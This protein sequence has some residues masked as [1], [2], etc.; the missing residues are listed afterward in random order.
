[1]EATNQQ[2]KLIQQFSS[3]LQ[4]G[5][6]KIFKLPMAFLAGIKIVKVDLEQV[7]TSL[8]YKYVN[9]NPFQSVYFAV[10]NMGAE[11]ASG[12][13]VMLQ[14]A[15]YKNKVS[16]LVV[17]SKSEYYKKATGKVFFTC[18]LT[19]ELQQTIQNTIQNNQASTCVLEVICTTEDGLIIGKY[20]FEW[21][22]KK[23]D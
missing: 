14:L 7:T 20:W 19:P 9:K 5:L 15:K 22:M 3:G 10:L 8:K 16:I 4:F 13:L 18:E 12:A 1:M 21:S 11:L 17:S 6:F 23:K 2:K